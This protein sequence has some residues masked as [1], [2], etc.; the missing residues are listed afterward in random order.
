MN[1]MNF[2]LASSITWAVIVVAPRS[3]AIRSISRRAIGR[4]K[5]GMFSS[6]FSA[7]GVQAI[8]LVSFFESSMTCKVM[9]V[10]P[11]LRA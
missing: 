4:M 2:S 5:S 3:F 1:F 8:P 10:Y 7:S 11:C 6:R 9:V